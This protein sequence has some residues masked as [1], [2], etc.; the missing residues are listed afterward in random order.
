[1]MPAQWFIGIAAPFGDNRLRVD[2]SDNVPLNDI[3]GMLL[4]IAEK[5]MDGEVTLCCS[6]EIGSTNSCSQKSKEEVE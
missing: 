6:P 5:I 1:M 4:E 3:P 2:Y